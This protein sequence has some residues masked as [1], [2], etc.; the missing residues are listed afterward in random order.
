MKTLSILLS[1]NSE[2]GGVVIILVICLVAFFL[3]RSI[4]LW[5]WKVDES[6]TQLKQLNA[7]IILLVKASGQTPYGSSGKPIKEEAKK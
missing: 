2:L 5:Y 3:L 6:I 4:M 1:S 7:N